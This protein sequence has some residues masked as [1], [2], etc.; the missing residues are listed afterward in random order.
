MGG[1]TVG[2]QA[3][4]VIEPLDG[5]GI[6]E[7]GKHGDL[8]AGWHPR[9]DIEMV[10]DALVAGTEFIIEGLR[11]A[12]PCDARL[13]VGIEA[14]DVAFQVTVEAKEDC[15]S[16]GQCT[17]KAVA[18]NPEGQ[19]GSGVEFEQGGD[20]RGN[21]VMHAVGETFVNLRIERATVD[22][23]AQVNRHSVEIAQP[24]LDAIL[25]CRGFGAAKCEDDFLRVRRDVALGVTAGE[26]DG[27]CGV[28]TED[29]LDTGFERCL[30]AVGKLTGE[31]EVEGVPG[32]KGGGGRIK[33]HGVFGSRL[34]ETEEEVGVESAEGDGFGEMVMARRFCTPRRRAG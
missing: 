8:G 14:P 12:G 5:S 9:D 24:V 4:V 30:V 17:A 18:G 20:D 34:G 1:A 22:V 15:G 19:A 3:A 2:V 27:F 7:G 10:D 25:A 13:A 28:E 32:V 16:D 29:T 11:E 6:R 31:G 21:H 33:A 23:V 26:G